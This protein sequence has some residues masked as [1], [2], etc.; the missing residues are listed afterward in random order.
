M[1]GPPVTGS[2]RAR[3]TRPVRGWPRAGAGGATTWAANAGRHRAGCRRRARRGHRPRPGS[4]RVATA[5]TRRRGAP[6]GLPRRVADPCPRL[7]RRGAARAGGTRARWRRRCRWSRA[8]ATRHGPAPTGRPLPGAQPRRPAL[9]RQ[10]S[11]SAKE[12]GRWRRLRRRTSRRARGTTV[13]RST[14]PPPWLG[15]PRPHVRRDPWE[16][17]PEPWPALE[18]EPLRLRP[19]ER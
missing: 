1:Q 13:G 10:A 12:N 9:P 5:R 18:P 6:A 4:S 15:S 3:A 8:A 14:A 7:R 17:R 2:R 19:G 16:R 11:S